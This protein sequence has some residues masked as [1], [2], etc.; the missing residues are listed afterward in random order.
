MDVEDTRAPESRRQSP[1]CTHANSRIQ[2][3]V[4]YELVPDTSRTDRGP[5]S[6]SPLEIQPAHPGMKLMGSG[7]P[8]E[9]PARGPPAVD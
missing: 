9:G 6:C 8:E 3:H 7:L 2:T 4:R 5:G 1:A